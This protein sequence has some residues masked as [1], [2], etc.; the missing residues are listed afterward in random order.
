MIKK[1]NMIETDKSSP[2]IIR[3]GWAEEVKRVL[4]ELVNKV[5]DLDRRVGSDMI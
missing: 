5:N 2:F 1:V 4:D 3:V